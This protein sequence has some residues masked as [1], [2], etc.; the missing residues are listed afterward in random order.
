MQRRHNEDSPNL[1]MSELRCVQS[2]GRRALEDD[3]RPA[4][5][6]V[7]GKTTIFTALACLTQVAGYQD[8]EVGVSLHGFVV[9]RP[10][11]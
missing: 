5:I 2:T 7:S 9:H 4:V 1:D 10:R 8:A 6:S 11:P 3:G